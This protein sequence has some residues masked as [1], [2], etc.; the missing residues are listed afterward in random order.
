MTDRKGTMK[1]IIA[2]VI[3]LL[4][5]VCAWGYTSFKSKDD[6]GEKSGKRISLI[7][8]DSNLSSDVEESTTAN[9]Q[10][11][12][13]TTSS[14]SEK[15]TT[16]ESQTTKTTA[17]ATT[18]QPSVVTPAKVDVLSYY[19]LSS[20]QKSLYQKLSN[21]V[22]D[23][24]S[25]VEINTKISQQE[26]KELYGI[27]KD[28]NYYSANIPVSFTINYI[29]STGTITSLE[30]NF[31]FD[32]NNG[33][34]KTIALKNKVNQ[35]KSQIP[36]GSDFE[37][38]K[39]IHD[40]IINNC[41]YNQ[42]AV[43]NPNSYPSSFTAYGA[44]VE[45]TAVCEGYSKAFSLLCEQVGIETLLVTGSANGIDHMWNMVKCNGQWYHI[46]VTWDDPVMDD[47]SADIHYTYFNV[48][49][50]QISRDHIISSPLLKVPTATA[51]SENYFVKLKLIANSYSE[52]K[53]IVQAE[54]I[55]ALQRGDN[56]ITIKA[57]NKS[58]YDEIYSKMLVN[59]GDIFELLYNAK[60]Q[61]GVGYIGSVYSSP[62][63]STSDYVITIQ[64]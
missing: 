55:K 58:V 57:A 53:S 62:K 34:Q 42:A 51:T 5:I 6:D 17:K 20:T 18:K 15:T 31:P 38:V 39:F 64:F 10:T 56:K 35:I 47:N 50:A 32:K 2:I 25:T 52:A 11:E 43:R 40:Y 30:F 7:E 48:T 28:L 61:A 24:V 27:V 59:D 19:N 23:S 16:S 41:E 60:S 36:N 12:V 54:A 29:P 33:V 63:D 8:D 26:L 46:D 1:L 22:T 3:S 45:G 4:I 13:N 37:K 9:S 14:K 21:A 44:L 49:T